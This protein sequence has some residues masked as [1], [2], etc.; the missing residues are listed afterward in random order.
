LSLMP[1]ADLFV[2]RDATEAE[3]RE[4]IQAYWASI[5]W[6]D[7]NVGRVIAELDKLGLRENT[8]IVFW[9][10][11]GYH[12]GEMGKWSKYGSLFEVGTRVPLIVV[13]PSMKANGQAVSPPVQ[14][15]DIYPTLCELCGLKLP[16]GL[17]GHSL[18]PLMNDPKTKWEYPAFTIAGQGPENLGVAVRTDKYR[19]AEWTGGKNGAMLFDEVADPLEEKNLADDPKF[20]EVRQQ[21]SNLAKTAAK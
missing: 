18:K 3:A 14:S 19:Y 13:A 8:I 11:H 2:K 9:G 4:M 6:V 20:A 17:E 15:M 1:N 7:W 10:D 5:S 16:A 21:L 12:L